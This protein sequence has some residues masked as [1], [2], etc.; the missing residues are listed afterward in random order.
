MECNGSPAQ[1]KALAMK[2]ID[3]DGLKVSAHGLR[4]MG[5]SEPADFVRP[6]HPVAARPSPD[7]N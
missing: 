4:C 6:R 5:M 7:R 2:R 1:R 3:L